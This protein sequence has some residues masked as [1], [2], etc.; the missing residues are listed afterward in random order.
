MGR[1]RKRT[2]KAE[3]APTTS[4]EASDDVIRFFRERAAGAN[5]DTA[6][7]VLDRIGDPEHVSDDD[8]L[9]APPT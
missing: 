7:A 6:L 8:R 2:G 3:A 4:P 1:K 5:V 9:D